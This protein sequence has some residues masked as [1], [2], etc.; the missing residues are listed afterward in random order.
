MDAV[1][2]TLVP[3]LVA[4]VEVV[5]RVGVPSKFCPLVAMIL[6]VGIN[7]G[8]KMVGVDVLEQVLFGI[9]AGLASNGLFDFGKVTVLNK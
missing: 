9:V 6:G 4:L 7:I 8:F 1:S 3:I 2:L 5:K